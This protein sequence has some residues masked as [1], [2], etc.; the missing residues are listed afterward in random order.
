[1]FAPSTCPQS[2]AR[3]E[4][5]LEHITKY[6]IIALQEVWEPRY[7]NVAKHAQSCKYYFVGSSSPSV[8]DVLKFRLFGGGLMIISKYPVEA[9]EEIT[10]VRGSHSDSFTTKGVL[11]ARIRIG[12]SKLHVFNTHLQASYGD[13]F[14]PNNFYA[15]I[16]KK[17]IQQ[18]ITFIKRVTSNDHYPIMLMGDFNVNA[19]RAPDDSRDSDEYLRMMKSLEGEL[20]E[21]VDILKDHNGGLH[22][23]THEG[24]GVLV[25]GTSTSVAGPQRLDFLLELRRRKVD[26]NT[27]KHKFVKSQ[28]VPFYVDGQKNFTQISDHFGTNV[29]MELGDIS[30]DGV[31]GL[32]GASISLHTGE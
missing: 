1:L 5:F 7:K 25:S 27:W 26:A 13:E 31:P 20:Y 16:R 19:R 14:D 10:Y 15:P 11:Y 17:Q 24:K 30:M 23:V 18:L 12:A 3:A 32:A 22:P 8:W 29:V 4:C 28:V 6:D 21:V 9:T 2:L